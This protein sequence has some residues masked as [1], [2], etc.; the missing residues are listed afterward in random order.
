MKICSVRV[1][2]VPGG[3]TDMT[4]LIVA[5]LRMRLKSAQNLTKINSLACF[6][7]RRENIVPAE[8]QRT[9]PSYD[10]LW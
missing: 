7:T 3:Q 1:G 8:I 5:G 6:A 10:G 9:K 4:K 2:V